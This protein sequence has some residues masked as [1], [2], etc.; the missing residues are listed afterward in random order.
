MDKKILK[1]R[2][3]TGLIFGS[4][5]IGSF[6]IGL[7]TTLFLLITIGFG[8]TKEYLQMVKKDKPVVAV[9]GSIIFLFLAAGF[10]F[11]K[12]DEKIILWLLIIN[13]ALF[14]IA[15]IHFWKPF[16]NHS[17]SYAVIS[18]FYTAIPVCAAIRE[19]NENSNYTMVLLGVL[20][21]IWASDSGAYFAGSLFGKTK[22][23]ERISPNKTWEGFIGGGILAVLVSLITSL[24][25]PEIG[26]MKWVSISLIVWVIGTLGDLM[27]SGIKR[28]FSVKDSGSILPGH[29]GFLDRFDSFIY[30]LPFILLVIFYI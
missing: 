30:V 10:Y 18:L 23:F 12:F 9:A 27:E 17:R 22:L 29:G 21:L 13:A 2:V 24:M 16:L 8:C 5:V 20:F 4:V 1:T 15:L 26:L 3:I 7:V 6:L 25:M 14:I 11:I 28:Q 19:L